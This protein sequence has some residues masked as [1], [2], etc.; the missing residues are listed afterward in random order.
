V[1]GTQNPLESGQQRRELVAGPG[2]IT[3]APGPGGEVV[4]SREGVR[5]LGTQDPLA[6]GQQGSILV[7][8]PGRIPRKPGPIGEVGPPR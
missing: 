2:G 8:G 3:G 5:V 1:L 6:D 7:A 4:P